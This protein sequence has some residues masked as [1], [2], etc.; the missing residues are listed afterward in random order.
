[1]SVEA[2]VQQLVA[3]L[4]YPMLIVTAAAAGERSGCLVG[5]STQCS[6]HPPRFLVCISQRNAT[7]A[8]AVD[9]DVLAVHFLGP[10][11]LELSK[12]FG[13]QTGDEVDKF[14]LCDWAPG[15]GGV[16]LL[17]GA[18]GY[19]VCRV[20]R[21][22]DGGDHTVFLVEPVA[23]EQRR[24]FSQLGFQDVKDMDPGHEA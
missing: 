4:N 15:P 5:F 22:D 18:A 23:A 20:L 19:M 8:V 12:L 13:E 11:D 2:T 21:R 3:S 24:S 9:S 10:E 7:H 1:M 16:P 6:I 14:S 17:A